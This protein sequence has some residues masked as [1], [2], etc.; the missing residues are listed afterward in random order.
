MIQYERR[1]IPELMDDPGIDADSHYAALK[2]LRRINHISRSSR[3]FWPSL[4][5]IA[6]NTPGPLRILD[7]A[8]EGGDVVVSLSR[9]AKLEGLNVEI[10]GYD[11]SGNKIG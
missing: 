1:V 7:V 4:R 8:S 3:V 2:R 5:Q 9:M 6:R 10:D 11:S